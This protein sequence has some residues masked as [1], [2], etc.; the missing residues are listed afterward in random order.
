LNE[1]KIILEQ[2]FLLIII[3]VIGYCAGKF[4]FLPASSDK[5]IASLVAKITAPLMIFTKV[6]NMK[7]GPENYI[8]GLKVYVFAVLFNLTGYFISL[9]FRKRFKFEGAASKIFSTQMMVG[10]VLYLAMPVI[11]ALSTAFPESWGN[12]VVYAMFFVLGNDTLMWTI[13]ISLIKNGG[14]SAK[15]TWKTRLKHLLNANSIAFAAGLILLFT[16][17]RDILTSV[18]IINLITDRLTLIGDMTSILS[19]MFIGIML[20]NIRIS[21]LFKDTMKKRMLLI[22]SSVK[23]LF[24]PL[25]AIFVLKLFSGFMPIEPA[26][27]VILQLSMPAGTLAVALAAEYKSDPEYTSQGVFLS[28][29]IFIF[30]L[31]FILWITEKVL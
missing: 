2:I 13:C 7:F 9:F 10:N 17:V 26:K 8:N 3:G 31:P 29:T 4:K 21:E 27:I 24:L 28:T 5:V 19:I 14:Q 22:S 15:I 1:T 11:L 16:G 6:Y 12:A 23:L 25:L 20:S 18:N 30:T